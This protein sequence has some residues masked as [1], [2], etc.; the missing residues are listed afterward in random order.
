M[1]IKAYHARQ[2]H[3]GNTVVPV[4]APDDE[5][6]IF[7]GRPAAVVHSPSSNVSS[8]ERNNS[9]P[10]VQPAP[11]RQATLRAPVARAPAA[12]P[13]MT[14]PEP[15]LAAFDGGQWAE[16]RL[17]Q[18]GWEGLFREGPGPGYG[19]QNEYPMDMTTDGGAMDDRWS[20]FMHNYNILEVDEPQQFHT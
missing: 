11:S 2:M 12:L 14:I 9:P 7:G 17:A 4:A 8:P 19:M 16:A 5:I 1:L 20:S 18:R 13:E 3:L 6:S 15:P 10:E